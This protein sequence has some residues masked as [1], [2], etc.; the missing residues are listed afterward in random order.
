MTDRPTTTHERGAYKNEPLQA[1]DHCSQKSNS[2]AH[3]HDAAR[4]YRRET[5]SRLCRKRFVVAS[6]SWRADE[7]RK[8]PR[9]ASSA[10]GLE[11]EDCSK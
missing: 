10:R 3:A 1:P 6:R 11:E 9:G 8:P 4:A 7:K 2:N 5:V